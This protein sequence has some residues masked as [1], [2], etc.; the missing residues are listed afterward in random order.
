LKTQLGLKLN[1]VHNNSQHNAT[2]HARNI[3]DLSFADADGSNI[4]RLPILMPMA[5]QKLLFSVGEGEKGG[6]REGRES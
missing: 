2:Q 5:C 1:I 4:N 3:S 6:E